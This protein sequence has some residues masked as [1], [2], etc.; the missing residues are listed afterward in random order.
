[1][2]AHGLSATDVQNALTNQNQIVPAGFA[3]IG[4]FQYA[5]QLNNA[6][7]T[8]EQMNNLPVKTV[9]GATIYMRD[10]AHV[11]DGAAAADQCRACR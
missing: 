1:M 9:N 4:S 2:Q 7:N 6:A 10:V 11:R 5:I 3:K 8:V